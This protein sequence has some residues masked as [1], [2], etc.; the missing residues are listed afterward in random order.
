M[1]NSVKDKF[2]SYVG[3]AMRANAVLYGEDIITERIKLAKVILIDCEA[4]D[5]YRDRLV[6]KTSNHCPVFTGVKLRQALH[7]EN[8]NA[9]AVTNDG[10]AK[11]II[12]LLR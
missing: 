5:K 12:E 11:A 2:S 3:L 1:T 9:I 6:N 4:T 7:R 10:L 8:V